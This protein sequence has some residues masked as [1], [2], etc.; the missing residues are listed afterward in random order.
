MNERVEVLFVRELSSQF[1]VCVKLIYGEQAVYIVNSYFKY[2][3]DIGPF[4]QYWEQCVRKL[5]T[6]AL[7][8]AGDVNAKSSLWHSVHT[9]SRGE[10]LEAFL[11]ANDLHVANEEGNLATF[12][13]YGE[14]VRGSGPMLIESNIDITL[15]NSCLLYTSL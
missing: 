2:S 6:R 13:T 4:I 1:H 10:D 9:D 14:R 11:V 15:R 5:G 8:L 7:I 12:A 3:D